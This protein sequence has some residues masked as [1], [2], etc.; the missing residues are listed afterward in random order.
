VYFCHYF[1]TNQSGMAVSA[2]LILLVAILMIGIVL[3]VMILRDQVVQEHRSGI[4]AN[5]FGK[6]A[7]P[8]LSD[9]M[10]RHTVAAGSVSTDLLG[11]RGR[12][13]CYSRRSSP[14]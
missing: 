3:A 12:P 8:S 1:W 14:D 9:A 5:R 11:N 13:G 2:E 7:S 6:T 10:R 4:L